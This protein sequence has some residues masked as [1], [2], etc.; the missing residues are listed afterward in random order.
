V[1]D[2]Q[3]QR[4]RFKGFRRRQVAKGIIQPEHGVTKPTSRDQFPSHVTWWCAEGVAAETFFAVV[5]EHS[6]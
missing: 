3:R 5:P 2:A 4:R 1:A 6:P